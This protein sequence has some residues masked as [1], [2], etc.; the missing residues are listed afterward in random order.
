[1]SLG[2]YVKSLS[3]IQLLLVQSCRVG[4][5]GSQYRVTP[6]EALLKPIGPHADDRS[7][8][9]N[10]THNTKALA[11]Q[12]Q[13]GNAK[14]TSFTLQGAA[15]AVLWVFARCETCKLGTG[16]QQG[17]FCEM[18][19]LVPTHTRLQG[20]RRLSRPGSAAVALK[21]LAKIN[22]QHMIRMDIQSD[23]TALVLVRVI[24]IFGT[25]TVVFFISTLP[26]TT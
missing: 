1:M 14:A 3:C 22:I 7:D 15:V 9:C 23:D 26:Y 2:R 6:V 11:C 18:C 16:T 17:V 25:A 20:Q 13:R 19:N 8:L 5:L 21:P 12:N 4:G 24:T 10:A